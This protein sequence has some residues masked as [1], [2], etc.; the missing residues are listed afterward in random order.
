MDGDSDT[1]IDRH[2][3]GHVREESQRAHNAIT[4]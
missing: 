4:F 3:F 1:C 2:Y